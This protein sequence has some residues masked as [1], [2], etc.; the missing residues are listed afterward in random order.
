MAFDEW[1]IEIAEFLGQKREATNELNGIALD[2]VLDRE[3]VE[4]VR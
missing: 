3:L 1:P 4:E 2:Q